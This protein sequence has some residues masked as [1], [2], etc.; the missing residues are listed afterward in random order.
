ME[1]FLLEKEKNSVI[2]CKN[3]KGVYIGRKRA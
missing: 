1:P 2:I 3:E